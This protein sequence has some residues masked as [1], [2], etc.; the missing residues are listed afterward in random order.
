M[1]RSAYCEMKRAESTP[2][3][4]RKKSGTA[5]MPRAGSGDR[6]TPGAD[7]SAGLAG[8]RKLRVQ[9]ETVSKIKG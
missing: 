3:Y 4:S 1:G 8:L 9:R 5:S 2:Y 7:C 6:W